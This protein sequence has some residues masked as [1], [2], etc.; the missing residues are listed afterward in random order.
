MKRK[1]TIQ[2]ASPYFSNKDE[3]WIKDQ[4]SNILQNK[5]STG[6][7]C[8]TFE[9]KFSKFIGTKYAVFVNSCTSALEIAT[10]FI[11]LKKTDEVIVPVQTFI[12]TGTAVNN[13]SGKVVFAEVNPNTFCL[14][15][16][17]IKK[18]KTKKTKAIMLV[19]F[20][21]YMS[22]DILKIKD[23]CKKN[24]IFI[25]EDCSHAFGTRYGNY[26]AGNIG[27]IGCFSFFSTKTLTTGEGGM[28]TTNSKK[29][30]QYAL[31]LRNRGE[32]INSPIEIYDKSWR[33][34][35]VPEFNAVLGLS[36]LSNIKKINNHREMITSIYDE[37]IK[38]EKSN[39]I[40]S[41]PRY[42]KIYYSVWKHVSIIK[43]PKIKRDN[44][45]KILKDKFNININ[46]AYTPLLHLQ[47]FYKKT[48]GT[49]QGDFP[50]TEDVASKHFHLPLHLKVTKNDAKY[51]VKSLFEAI[52]ILKR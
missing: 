24:N 38:K 27:E 50:V 13:Q 43:N 22:N 42:E 12:A 18:R 7:Y 5:L 10:K 6:P 21:G 23:Y 3:K 11:D 35:R 1:N 48:M 8:N 40:Y 37:G 25:I 26:N 28:L 32:K 34:C 46:W 33:N 15:L 30:Y 14:D 20:A 29:I 44:L 16:S 47:P 9:K 19:H 45:Q 4:I 17:E 52:K 49:K 51:I 41:L 2:V 31:S 39:D 36:Q